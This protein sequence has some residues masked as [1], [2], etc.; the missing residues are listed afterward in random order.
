M[1]EGESGSGE[2]CIVASSREGGEEV[3]RVRISRARRAAVR[4]FCS[5]RRRA[6]ACARFC[7]NNV[8]L[9]LRDWIRERRWGKAGF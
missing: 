8:R 5:R 7:S 3:L 4:V 6:E 1:L 9:S 2:R